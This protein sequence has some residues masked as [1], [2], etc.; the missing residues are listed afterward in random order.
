MQKLLCG[1]SLFEVGWHPAE[2]PG[3]WA[4]LLVPSLWSRPAHTVDQW[5]TEGETERFGGVWQVD[6]LGQ[7]GALPLP[8]SRLVRYTHRQ[9]GGN[10][11]GLADARA[12]Y[13]G[14]YF[15]SM[16]MRHWGIRIERWSTG[17][18]TAE[19]PTGAD[20]GRINNVL[21]DIRGNEKAYA[22]FPK[23]SD[24]KIVFPDG[25][26]EQAEFVRQCDWSIATA[27]LATLLPASR[28]AAAYTIG[29]SLADLLGLG[30][31]ADA[32]QIE[33]GINEDHDGWP[34]VLRLLTEWNFPPGT[35]V[36]RLTHARI[37]DVG[38]IIAQ[39]IGQAVSMGAI[40]GDDSIDRH[41]RE[42]L[43]APPR[44]GDPLPTPGS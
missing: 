8:S 21:R 16:A 30:M 37:R 13:P 38:P 34:G 25:E 22:G 6:R 12:A 32:A 1:F 7:P 33:R 2:P 39:A 23:G 4:G 3:P 17:I 14:W 20:A 29:A 11:E 28:D 15:K 27:F 44:E 35:A 5:L 18:P 41:L 26:A 9:H 40:V 31:D 19:Y 43:G 36:P 42:I 10:W 24:F